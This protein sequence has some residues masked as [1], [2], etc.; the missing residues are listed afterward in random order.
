MRLWRETDRRAGSSQ[1]G[2]FGVDSSVLCAET[3][4]LVI[5]HGFANGC[6]M[7]IPTELMQQNCPHSFT[8]LFTKH[9]MIPVAP[10]SPQAT[11]LQIATDPKGSPSGLHLCL[12]VDLK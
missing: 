6:A 7:N 1:E 3:S 11:P 10:S 9:E 12:E 2:E 5:R 8:S 4:A